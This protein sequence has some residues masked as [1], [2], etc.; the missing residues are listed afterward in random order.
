VLLLTG[1][2]GA[3]ALPSLHQTRQTR[4]DVQPDEQMHVIGN[5][6]HFQNLSALLASHT[7]KEPHQESCYPRVNQRL[8]VTGGPHHMGVQSLSHGPIWR[9][10]GA[11][12]HRFVAIWI[13]PPRRR[14]QRLA[15]PRLPGTASPSR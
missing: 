14:L 15:E 12:D 6:T 13:I 3:S 9:V 7:A 1:N 11:P 10:T 4:G 2:R 5:Q 8:S